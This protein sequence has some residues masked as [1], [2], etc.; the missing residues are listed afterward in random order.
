MNAQRMDWRIAIGLEAAIDEYRYWERL[1]EEHRAKV[2]A[3][4][5]DSIQAESAKQLAGEYGLAF[6][7]VRSV[8]SGFKGALG[9][10]SIED[11]A[12]MAAESLEERDREI[13]ARR[14]QASV[15]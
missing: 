3:A 8:F 5:R 4:D 1:A 6:A 10:K 14:T 15:R 9:V 7:A 2:V 12:T 13:S 11:L